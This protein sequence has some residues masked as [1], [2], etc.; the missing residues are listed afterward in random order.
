MNSR[1]NNNHFNIGGNCELENINLVRQI[2]NILSNKL[3]NKVDFKKLITFV[4]DRPDMTID[5]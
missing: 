3:N 5:T 1:C 2:C 4:H